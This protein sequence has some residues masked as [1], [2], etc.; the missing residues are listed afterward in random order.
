MPRLIVI[1]ALIFA[2]AGELFAQ[3]TASAAGTA[4]E[5]ATE[6]SATVPA[7]TAAAAEKGAVEDD[8]LEA[9]SSHQVRE[10]FTRLLSEHPPQL[11]RVLI[12]DPT[13]LTNEPFLVRYPNVADFLAKH[14][15]IRRNPHYYLDTYEYAAPRRTPFEDA[16]ETLTILAVFIFI[17]FVLAWAAR[18]VI[19]QRRW[20]RLSARQAEIHNRILDRFATSEELLAYI[21]TPAGTKFLES[22]P[23]PVHAEKAPQSSSNRVV[24][25]I[26]IGVI[27][28]AGGIGMLLVS[29]RLNGDA[30]HGFFA[31]GM[32]AFCIG[33]GF[34]G[35][36][37]VSV[38]LARR[39]GVWERPDPPP[40]S[41]M[42]DSGVVR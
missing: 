27:V 35:S 34:I 19:E 13:L 6:T 20:N 2:I 40:Q 37:A 33:A 41:N 14:P 5:T 23:I 25:S 3:E 30:S 38:M 26:Q 28:A 36:S 7:E 24:R 22:A 1:L 39:L 16:V 32:I 11:T 8:A 10:A 29:L 4:T 17:A 42:D 9:A 18:T 21:K 12:T 15:E 31:M